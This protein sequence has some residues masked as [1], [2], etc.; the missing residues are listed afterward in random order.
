[1]LMGKYGH[2]SIISILKKRKLNTK[3]TTEA[4]LIGADDVMPHMLWTRYFL[5]AQRYGID[6]N[7]FYQENMSA[8]FLENT[9]KKSS[10]KKTK[11]IKVSYY[12]IKD[13]V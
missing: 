6:E 1:M 9:G 8:M 4:K 11:H 2:R 12:F 5:E 7:I 3:M 13:Q 10:T